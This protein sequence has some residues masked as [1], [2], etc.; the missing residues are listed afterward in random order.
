MRKG[1]GIRN[2]DYCRKGFVFINERHRFCSDECRENAYLRGSLIIFERDGFKCI[3]CGRTSYHDGVKLTIDH[4]RPITKKGRDTADNLVTAC[5][6]C[7]MEKKSRSLLDQ[8]E[9]LIRDEVAKRNEVAGINHKQM[10]KIKTEYRREKLA[11][12]D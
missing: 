7:N 1:L 5:H 8:A 6:T 9:D 4:I 11:K 2:C 3:Y 10:I 12:K